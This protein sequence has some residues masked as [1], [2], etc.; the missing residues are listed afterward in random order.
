MWTEEVKETSFKINLK[1][2]IVLDPKLCSISHGDLAL[3]RDF[4]GFLFRTLIYKGKSH[5]IPAESKVAVGNRSELW[6]QCEFFLQISFK[7]HL[8]DLFCP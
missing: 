7:T 3:S 2:K 1:E 4:L 8:L 6:A 5:E